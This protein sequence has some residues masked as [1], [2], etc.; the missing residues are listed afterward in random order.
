MKSDCQVMDVLKHVL[1]DVLGDKDLLPELLKMNKGNLIKGILT[2]IPRVVVCDAKI[3][4][5]ERKVKKI[6]V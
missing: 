1:D 5:L 2:L 6:Q 3:D 4:K